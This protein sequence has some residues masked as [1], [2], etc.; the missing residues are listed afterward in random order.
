M[1]QDAN[2]S[3]QQEINYLH[4][5]TSGEDQQVVDNF[6]KQIQSNPVALLSD[7]WKELEKCFGSAAVITN[8]LLSNLLRAAK[9]KENEHAKL[10]RFADVCADVDSQIT[11]LAG[12]A[13]LNF[14]NAIAPIVGKLPASLKGKWEKEVVAFAEQNDDRYPSFSRFKKVM[15]R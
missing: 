7:V 5:Y 8:A 13:C 6:R 9:F 15:E 10:Q 2:V 14:P 4:K 3:P 1:I 11:Q 12:L